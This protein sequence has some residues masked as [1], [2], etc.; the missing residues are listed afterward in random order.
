[1]L[2]RAIRQHDAWWVTNKT[3]DGSPILVID[4]KEVTHIE[5]IRASFYPSQAA[6]L[7]CQPPDLRPI[8]DS[9]TP[10]II[11]P[12][13]SVRSALQSVGYKIVEHTDSHSTTTI[14]VRPSIV[15]V[16]GD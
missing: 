16:I 14:F 13:E 6:P 11:G 12:L 10:N 7:M 1:M 5:P 9:G 8:V 15:S 2:R 4:G 3:A